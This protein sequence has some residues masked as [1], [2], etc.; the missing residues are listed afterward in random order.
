MHNYMCAF[1]P[2]HEHLNI[3]PF[4]SLKL[5]NRAS[6]TDT[7]DHVENKFLKKLNSFPTK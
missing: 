5:L 1:T 6:H 4:G 2:V 7:I 3:V